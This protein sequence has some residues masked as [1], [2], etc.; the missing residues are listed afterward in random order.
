MLA[1]KWPPKRYGA[2]GDSEWRQLLTCWRCWRRRA[3][4]SSPLAVAIR[5]STHFP[6]GTNES[7][8][9]LLNPSKSAER[10]RFDLAHELGHLLLHGGSLYESD[11]KL[12]ER[13]AN[14]FASAFLMPRAGL[15]GSLRGNVSLDDL[16]RLRD[17]WKVSAMAMTVRLH[18]L[19]V[20]TDW[21]YRLMCQE[22]SKRGFRRGEPGS[23][24]IPES[25]SLW[26]QI[27]GDLRKR[28]LGFAFLASIIG[29][30]AT[31]V[32]SLLVGLVPIAI[33]G[34]ATRASQRHGNLHLV[35]D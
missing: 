11:G 6:F 12:R 35:A 25:S 20:V 10:L 19:N 30:R 28:N 33:A 3:L 2:T 18:Q 17:S 16:P 1:L 23:T 34:G 5:L 9:I 4:E 22:L 8:I 32:R 13:Q 15:L 26:A 14:D 31:D 7:A 21:T 24:L 27:L 29:V